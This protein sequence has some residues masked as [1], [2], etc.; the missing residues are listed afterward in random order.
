MYL[1]IGNDEYEINVDY[2]YI[3]GTKGAWADGV[4]VE[5][6][7]QSCVEINSVKVDI[8][9]EGEV[10]Q[11]AFTLLPPQVIRDLELEILQEIEV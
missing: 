9:D 3:K 4:Q 7:E 8:A 2:S 5:P 1:M 6:D 11:L 10:Q